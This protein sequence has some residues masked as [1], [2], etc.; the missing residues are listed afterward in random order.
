MLF[1]VFIHDCVSQLNVLF[2]FFL[3]D[4]LYYI[5]PLLGSQQSQEQ[6][7]RRGGSSSDMHNENGVSSYHILIKMCASFSNLSIVVISNA[8]WGVE[9]H[10]LIK[11]YAFLLTVMQS[12]SCKVLAEV[13][14]L[15]Y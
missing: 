4:L 15:R 10:T 5:S 1:L 7:S 12:S 9:F 14:T 13:D 11:S 6:P 3:M 8:S 2:F